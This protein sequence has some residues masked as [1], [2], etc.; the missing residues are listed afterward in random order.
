MEL[1]ACLDIVKELNNGCDIELA[2]AIIEG[3][4]HS[5]MSFGLVRSM[6]ESFCDRGAEFSESLK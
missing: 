6:V 3:Q 4:G 2:K 1:G 5:G